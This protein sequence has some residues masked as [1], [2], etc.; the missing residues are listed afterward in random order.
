MFWK[1][2]SLDAVAEKIAALGV[3]GLILAIAIS[4]S[5]YAGGAAIVSVLAT[6]GGPLGMIGGIVLL[7]ILVL[8]SNAIAT[9]GA[10]VVIKKVIV[11]L[12]TK[13]LSK[14]EVLKKINSYP[15]S[16]GLKLKAKE[17]IEKYWNTI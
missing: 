3:P 7:G 11:N 2:L 1:K 9:Y 6:M 17:Y 15:I 13:G 5:G 8:I 12:K 4:Y 14:E 10:E 16:M